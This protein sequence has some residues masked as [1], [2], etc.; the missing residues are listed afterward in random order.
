MRPGHLRTRG[1]TEL[2]LDDDERVEVSNLHPEN[3]IKGGG[4]QSHDRT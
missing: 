3:Q 4:H 1:K 2:K